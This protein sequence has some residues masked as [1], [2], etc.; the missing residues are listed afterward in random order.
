MT[1]FCLCNIINTY[2]TRREGVV[3][4]SDLEPEKKE[5]IKEFVEKIESLDA[6]GL[7]LLQNSVDTLLIYQKLKEHHEKREAV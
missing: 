2:R 7:Y 6:K 3:D 5:Q 4:M 1:K